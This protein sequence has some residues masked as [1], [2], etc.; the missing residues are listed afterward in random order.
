[1]LNLEEVLKKKKLYSVTYRGTAEDFRYWWASTDKGGAESFDKFLPPIGTTLIE[2]NVVCEV[3]KDGKND[4]ADIIE[5]QGG[6]EKAHPSII[7]G[8][9]T[10]FCCKTTYY[11]LTDSEYGWRH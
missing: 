7:R 8:N 3:M 9:G 2:G 11:E 10:I 5:K 4:H 6:K 1:M